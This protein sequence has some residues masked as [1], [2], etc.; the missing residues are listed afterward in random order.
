MKPLERLTQMKRF[1]LL[2]MAVGSTMLTIPVVYPKLN[3]QPGIWPAKPVA[4]A[5]PGMRGAT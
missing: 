5:V 4:P 1:A 3:R 2:L